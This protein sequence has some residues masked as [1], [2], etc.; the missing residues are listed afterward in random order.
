MPASILLHLPHSSHHHCLPQ[1]NQAALPSLEPA[2][3]SNFSLYKQQP[4]PSSIQTSEKLPAIACN[5]LCPIEFQWDRGYLFFLTYVCMQL[6]S[7]LKL[8][9]FFSNHSR[10]VAS[11]TWATQFQQLSI[12][13]FF[14][15]IFIFLRR[16]LRISRRP[17]KP[18]PNFFL[19][20]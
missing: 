7:Y 11:T 13:R 10:L 20:L 1:L 19:V 14:K 4:S 18:R 15:L 16:L 12:L 3:K 6:L 5:Q 8:Q 2:A 9:K 17:K